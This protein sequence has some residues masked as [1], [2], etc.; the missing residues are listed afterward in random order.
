MIYTRLRNR[1][2]QRWLERGALWACL[3][4]ASHLRW[5]AEQKMILWAPLKLEKP[6]IQQGPLAVVLR[7]SLELLNSLSSGLCIWLFLNFHQL[8]P[9]TQPSLGIQNS[10]IED[11]CYNCGP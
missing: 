2:Y 3:V 9:N 7:R 4:G 5:S 8:S 11:P 1:H 6:Q 10:Q